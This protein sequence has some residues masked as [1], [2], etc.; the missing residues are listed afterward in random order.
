VAAAGRS[1]WWPVTVSERS[2]KPGERTARN[3]GFSAQ[4]SKK[5]KKWFFSMVTSAKYL[6]KIVTSQNTIKNLPLR[7][8]PT[9]AIIYFR[10]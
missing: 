3:V 2:S 10:T 6:R 8:I 4:P 9:K 7:K 5:E 1:E